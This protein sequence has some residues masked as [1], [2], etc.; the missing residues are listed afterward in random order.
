LTQYR[1]I[2]KVKAVYFLL[3]GSNSSPISYIIIWTWR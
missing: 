2:F 1:T 3:T